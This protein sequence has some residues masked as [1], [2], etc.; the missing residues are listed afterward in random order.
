[1]G[2]RAA[3]HR[4]NGADR[5]GPT[6]PR[7]GGVPSEP[8]RTQVIPSDRPRGR[9]RAAAYG[10]RVGGPD[11]ADTPTK[12]GSRGRL[13]RESGYQ[14]WP[15]AND[16]QTP[17]VPGTKRPP[18]FGHPSD[19]GLRAFLSTARNEPGTGARRMSRGSR[20]RPLL[21][22]PNTVDSL[23]DP[24]KDAARRPLESR[25]PRLGWATAPAA[26]LA[27]KKW[28]AQSSHAT[29]GDAALAFHI[30]PPTSTGP[31][32][33]VQTFP[34]PDPAG[35]GP[36]LYGVVRAS[37]RA[38]IQSGPLWFAR[39]L[40]RKGTWSLAPSCARAR[41][42]SWPTA[43]A[44]WPHSI[45]AL[46]SVLFINYISAL[47]PAPA[48]WSPPRA[49]PVTRC[50]RARA[51][52][53]V[54]P[55]ARAPGLYRSQCLLSLWVSVYGARAP[56]L[57]R[58]RCLAR[59]GQWSLPGARAP[60]LCR[61]R[62]LCRCVSI[63]VCR[64]RAPLPAGLP[65]P[66]KGP[67]QLATFPRAPAPRPVHAGVRPPARRL[68]PR[69]LGQPT[70]HRPP[71]PRAHRRASPSLS[72]S[73]SL[74]SSPSP[75]LVTLAR[76]PLPVL[77]GA[78]PLVPITVRAP[79]LCPLRG[80]RAGPTPL[81][82]DL[83]PALAA[84]LPAC[85]PRAPPTALLLHIPTDPDRPA[86]VRAN[87]PG[88]E[89]R[90]GGGPLALAARAP[91]A[92]PCAPAN[93]PTALRHQA[94]AR[95][96]PAA[97]QGARAAISAGQ[98]AAGDK[99]PY[100]RGPDAVPPL[101]SGPSRGRGRA[102]TQAV[103]EGSNDARTGMP[104]G[105]P[106]GAILHTFRTAFMLGSSAGAGPGREASP[107]AVETAGPPKQQGSPTETLLRLL[108]PLNDRIA[109]A[110]LAGCGIRPSGGGPDP[111]DTPTKGRLPRGGSP[112][113][114]VSGL[115][116]GQRSTDSIGA[117]DQTAPGFGHPAMWGSRRFKHG[118]KRA[119]TGPAIAGSRR[120]HAGR[121]EHR[122]SLDDPTKDAAR[123]PSRV[124]TTAGMGDCPVP[125]RAQLR[126][127]TTDLDR[128]DIV[129]ANVPGSGPGWRGA[130][131]VWG[132][133]CVDPRAHTKWASLVRPLL[134]PQGD[135]VTRAVLRARA[136]PVVAN[137]A[138]PLAPFHSSSYICS[139]HQLHICTPPAPANW[140]PP[141]ARPVTRCRRA[142][143]GQL[144]TPRRAPR[145]LSIPVPVCLCGC[146]YMARAPPAYIDPVSVGA[147]R[148][149]GHSGARARPASVD[150]AS[151]SV[152]LYKAP[153]NW[154]PSRARP[155]PR[156]VHAGV[157]PPARRLPPRQL[158]QPT[159][160]RPPPP[161]AHRRAPPPSPSPS[162][163]S[164]ALPPPVTLA[165]APLP[166]LAGAG[167][168]VPIT[169]RARGSL[170][171]T[172]RARPNSPRPRPG[173]RAGRL[174]AC[175]PACARASDGPFLHIP[176]DPDRPAIVRANVPG[177][178]SRSG[179]GPLALAARAPPARPCAPANWPPPFV[180]RRRR[181][182]V[183]AAGQG[184]RAAISAG[185][186]A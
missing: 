145:P 149:T 132:G 2:A 159:G 20:A 104:P 95:A 154:P 181:A 52:Q 129:R 116:S 172:G 32:S 171:A 13:P 71:P 40:G 101:P 80:A 84:C 23:D 48:N 65:P 42:R 77:A 26:C 78:G 128:A 24:T 147:R 61:P 109:L 35:G 75:P 100:A 156:P 66:P 98:L 21:D 135:L 94:A 88:S 157:R 91:P 125:E 186:L 55:A 83:D 92:R 139:V 41:G 167:P 169:V 143:A 36:I 39:C 53:L 45:P 44:P 4:A 115:A 111:A 90:S 16:P 179:G 96:G 107:A 136:G 3:G 50:R 123:R 174:P 33:C 151:V 103:L 113:N 38:P 130:H 166:V 63:S 144:V 117:G 89:S 7:R 76:A 14:D 67:R 28:P 119:G 8:V 126:E 133:P 153:A 114:R 131:F 168:L 15:A 93:W 54:T 158:G 18:G 134:G 17:S 184:A 165:R 160:H 106:G 175:L 127:L 161:R 9:W 60:G 163:S 10:P 182:R 178:E 59:A 51:G 43:P 138:G 148:P 64:W 87:V 176:T 150:P 142:R 27:G 180:T 19:V 6:S 74:L 152:C 137:G 85:L 108:L 173:P 146:L 25:K 69:Q 1:M 99:A 121:S 5:A 81:D 49:R 37:T 155:A 30:E 72:L 73:L 58:P 31:T 46:T 34:G 110:A 118:T 82:L 177:S 162:P 57:H 120:A 112:G 11:P 97:G 124:E 68:P 70:G 185:Q 102:N 79:A 170:P 164:L 122:D 56:G 62:R 86:I 22:A 29:R 183:P 105:I 140:S 47:P 12:G 141:R